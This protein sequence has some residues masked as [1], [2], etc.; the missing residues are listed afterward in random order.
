MRSLLATVAVLALSSGALAYCPPVPDV[1][2]DGYRGNDLQRTLC[3]QN[4]LA[5]S[6]RD[7]AIRSEIDATLSK[8]QRDLQQQKML[9]QQLQ[10][11]L[12]RTKPSS[13]LP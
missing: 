11:E 5:Q 13:L 10:I 1:A 6:A 4:E 12:M 9:Q 8:L 2:K 3:L 7:R